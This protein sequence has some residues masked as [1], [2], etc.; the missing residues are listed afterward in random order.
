[1]NLALFAPATYQRLYNCSMYNVSAIPVE[2]RQNMPMGI[3]Y[4]L[5]WAVSEIVY[6]P[7]LV[8]IAR[9]AANESCY[10]LMLFIGVADAI[11]LCIVGLYTGLAAL[12]G[13]VFC[14]APAANFVIGSL[15]VVFWGCSSMGTITLALN[16][17]L[18]LVARNLCETLFNDSRTYFWLCGIVVYALYYGLFNIP[19]L[20]SGV[21]SSWAYDPHIGY[22]D[23]DEG[24]V[25]ALD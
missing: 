13:W 14:S 9:H 15:S 17:V 19:N 4:V 20:Y 21:I 25:S 18:S 7:C 3:A 24:D 12:S 16:R 1:M 22:L 8:V 23:V 5:A 2:A 10:K 6:L 11:N